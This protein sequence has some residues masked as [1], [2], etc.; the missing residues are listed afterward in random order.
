MGLLKGLRHPWFTELPWYYLYAFFAGTIGVWVG[1][2]LSKRFRLSTCPYVHFRRFFLIMVVFL[3]LML[4]IGI[5]VALYP[6]LA[7]LLFGAAM[8]IR[9]PVARIILACAAPLGLVRLIFS[10]WSTLFIRSI[11]VATP[12]EGNIGAYLPF[13]LIPFFTVYLLPISS[14]AMAVIRDT[15][16]L[17]RLGPFL[18]SRRFLPAA[19]VVFAGLSV[20]YLPRPVYNRFWGCAVRLDESVDMTDRTDDVTLRGMDYITGAHIRYAGKDTVVTGRTAS[21][22]LRDRP[23]V[24]T[25][26]VSVEHREQR[27]ASG[28]ASAYDVELRLRTKEPP[29]TVAVSYSAGKKEVDGFSS[30]LVHRRRMDRSEEIE[31]YSYPDT[32]LTAPVRF[33]VS[34]DETVR[35]TITVVFS[36][37]VLPVAV[38]RE[39]TY[40]VPR[41]TYTFTRTY[42]R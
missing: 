21:V 18:R 3:V 40:V 30:P 2:A 16:R 29:Y 33:R 41:T 9:W 11:A 37:A 15:P 39:M 22:T 23:P 31:W 34:G 7:L 20:Y 24:D 32:A 13:V 6:A 36:R 14:G 27:T 12:D 5:K 25:S 42:R 19:L 26:L 4:L 1:A 38:E 10:E 35:E 8:L 17:G 28:E